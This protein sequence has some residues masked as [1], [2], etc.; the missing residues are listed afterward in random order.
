MRPAKLISAFLLGL[1]LLVAAAFAALI[2]IDPTLFRSQLEGGASAA[3]GRGVHFGGPI[4]LERS[5]Q[6]RIVVTQMTIDNPPWATAAHLAAADEVAVQVALWPLLFGELRVLDVGLTGVQVFLEEGPDGADNFTFGDPGAGQ[7]H[8]ALP[9]LERLLVQDAVITHRSATARLSRYEI[10][11]ARLWNL[12]DQP[13]RV[14]AQ[15]RA[16]G[17]PFRITLAADAPAEASDPQNPWSVKL[18][19]AAPGLSLTAAGRVAQVFAW[20]DFQFGIALSGDRTDSLAQLLE[21]EFPALGP[22]ELSATVM[23]EAEGRYRVTDLGAHLQGISGVPDITIAGGSAS[24]GRET[25]LDITLQGRFGD[26]PLAVTFFSE[27]F[28]DVFSQTTPWPMAG[29]FQ[30]ADAELEFRGTLTSAPAGPEVALEALLQ[31]ERLDSLARYLGGAPPKAGPYRLAFQALIVAGG[32]SFT[33][34]KGEIG[35]RAPL[36]AIRIV[37]GNA[38]VR[39]GGAVAGEI[40]AERDGVPLSLSFQGGPKKVNDGDTT[41]WPL[42]LTASAAGTALA[43]DGSIATTPQGRS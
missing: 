20:N 36:P 4:R 24:G 32:V 6:P 12:P 10:E 9:A 37:G 29:R 15:G 1:L 3:F 25:P 13:E 28:P 8:G 31:G 7:D 18:E 33:D 22:F 17:V 43:A 21:V 38:S 11:T 2:F 35:G 19:M 5:L 30:L 39:Q 40:T 14:E 27:R 42:K 34:L 16:K 41:D 26:A 23:A